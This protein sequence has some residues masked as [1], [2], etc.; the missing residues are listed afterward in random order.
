MQADLVDTVTEGERRTDRDARHHLLVTAARDRIEAQPLTI[1]VAAAS[2]CHR[3]RGRWH[4]HALGRRRQRGWRWRRGR[5]A[6]R[7]RRAGGQ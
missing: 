6:R 2:S 7:Q 1:P 3:C 4:L 5:R